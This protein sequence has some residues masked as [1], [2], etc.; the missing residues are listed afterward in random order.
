MKYM[1]MFVRSEEDWY[2][3]TDEERDYPAI[4]R[5]F[6]ELA[7]KG[8]MTGGEELQSARTATTVSW[9]GDQPILTDGPFIEAK[10]TIG[11]YCVI[12]APDLDAAIE[13]AK[14][15]PAAGRQVEIR[16]VVPH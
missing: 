12:E 10:E 15:W 7:Q 13:I 6:G 5:W 3:L 1:L 14:T 16:P 9:N 2:A 4:D 11:G 8:L